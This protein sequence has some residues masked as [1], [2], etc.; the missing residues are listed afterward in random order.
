M[1]LNCK[2]SKRT[3]I[4]VLYHI[5]SLSSSF[6]F[7]QANNYTDLSESR[8]IVPG[9]KPITTIADGHDRHAPKDIYL[10]THPGFICVRELMALAHITNNYFRYIYVEV[11]ISSALGRRRRRHSDRSRCIF[12]RQPTESTKLGNQVGANDRWGGDDDYTI[13]AHIPGWW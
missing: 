11:D 3:H 5:V 6:F 13:C 10:W 7:Y 12:D 1:P 2:I 9:P 4:K 8:L